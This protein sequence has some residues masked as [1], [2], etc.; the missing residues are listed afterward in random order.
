MARYWLDDLQRIL[1]Q[2]PQAPNMAQLE[3]NN[4]C[5]LDC[6]MCPRNEL[7]IQLKEMDFEVYSNTLYKLRDL[8]INEIDIGGWGEITYHSRFFEL[9][10]LAKELGFKVY[11]TS[12]GLLLNQKKL[13]RLLEI[14][15]DGITFS[16]DS[17]EKQTKDFT[18]H[19][20][21]PVWKK[22]R[23]LLSLR[24]PKKTHVKVNTLV[25]KA[26]YHEVIAISNSLDKLK[27]DMHIIF[28]PNISRDIENLRVPYDTEYKLYESIE[29]LRESKQWDMIVSTPLGRY[30][31]DKRR[32]HFMLG[33]RC[34]QTWQNIYVNRSGYVT[35]CTLLPDWHI[36][37]LENITN[38]DQLWNHKR[39]KDFRRNQ[40]HYCDGC[41]AMKFEKHDK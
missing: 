19:I 1:F 22:L 23:L 4:A 12:N 37:K 10:E 11:F 14:G 6:T 17:A 31:K 41:D 35:P 8:N 28:G 21:V 15:L 26:N 38:I 18:G 33:E 20:N 16:I 27:I 30:H 2:V 7:N 39:Y 3:A 36:D 40:K 24:D 5:N 25:Q 13:E 29:E 9:I 32:Y 34:P